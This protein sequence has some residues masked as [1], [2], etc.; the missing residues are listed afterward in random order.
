MQVIILI[1]MFMDSKLHNV[2]F[3]VGMG[4]TVVDL[5]KKPAF[6]V[7][8]VHFPVNVPKLNQKLWTL[9]KPRVYVISA[10]SQLTWWIL[11]AMHVLPQLNFLC[12]HSTMF[13]G[14]P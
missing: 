7:Y 2:M 10:A 5:G 13:F 1:I 14:V 8:G 11:S 3:L 4:Y 12:H 9:V 6:S